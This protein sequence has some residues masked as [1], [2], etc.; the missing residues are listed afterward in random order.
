MLAVYY[1][2]LALQLFCTADSFPTAFTLLLN[3]RSIKYCG[4]VTESR[5][6]INNI[7]ERREWI[8]GGLAASRHACH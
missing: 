4:S 7:S 6:S 2:L 5:V 8:F 3:H 1:W